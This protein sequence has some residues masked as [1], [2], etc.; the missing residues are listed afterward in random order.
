MRVY[1]EEIIPDVETKVP[2]V[3]DFADICAIEVVL[4]ALNTDYSMDADKA[5]LMYINQIQEQTPD[6]KIAE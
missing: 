5:V 6:I 2:T 1:A 4:S 3:Y